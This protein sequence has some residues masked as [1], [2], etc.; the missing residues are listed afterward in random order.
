MEELYIK[1]TTKE[2]E[3]PFEDGQYSTNLGYTE[4]FGGQWIDVDEEPEW[5]MEPLEME[6]AHGITTSCIGRMVNEE[7]KKRNL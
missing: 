6:E 2:Y 7:L 5:W 1:R 3:M 4:V